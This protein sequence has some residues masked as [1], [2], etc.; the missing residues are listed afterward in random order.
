MI[1]WI[2]FSNSKR[3]GIYTDETIAYRVLNFLTNKAGHNSGGIP[4]KFYYIESIELD[5]LPKGMA[6]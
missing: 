3:H 4:K 5:K 6:F 2:V 1:V